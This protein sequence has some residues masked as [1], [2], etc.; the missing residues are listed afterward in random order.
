M[1]REITVTYIL[2][3]LPDVDSDEK[4]KHESTLVPFIRFQ[5]ELDYAAAELLAAYGSKLAKLTWYFIIR[6]GGSVGKDGRLGGGSMI[7]GTKRME[8]RLD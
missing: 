2:E 6:D 3:D 5:E 1:R 7:A 8:R 4:R